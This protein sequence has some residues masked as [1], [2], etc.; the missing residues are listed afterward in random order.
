MG[1]GVKIDPTHTRDLDEVLTSA[2]AGFDAGAPASLRCTDA[3]KCHSLKNAED[4]RCGVTRL[5]GSV[6][7][8]TR[9]SSPPQGDSFAAMSEARTGRHPVKEF[10]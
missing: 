6:A 4:I 1:V 10:T 8:L 3:R 5:S 9:N 2:L 7:S